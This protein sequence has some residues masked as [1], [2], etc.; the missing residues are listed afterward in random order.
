MSLLGQKRT[1]HLRS[2]ST[3]VRYYP[4]ADKRGRAELSAVPIADIGW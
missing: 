3:V 2:N 1:N 4:K